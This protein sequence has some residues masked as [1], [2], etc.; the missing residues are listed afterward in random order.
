MLVALLVFYSYSTRKLIW[1]VSISMHFLPLQSLME[2]MK[3]KIETSP[4]WAINPFP[5]LKIPKFKFFQSYTY[6]NM[7]HFWRKKF[8]LFAVKQDWKCQKMSGIQIKIQNN[9]CAMLQS[10]ASWLS[11][12]TRIQ[13]CGG[14][15]C[16][17]VLA[18]IQI[19]ANNQP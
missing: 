7:L 17:R 14:R 10:E 19:L 3:L 13:R 1:L 12:P 8:I 16:I 15:L 9:F 18:K 5:L 6:K 11:A 4:H 2:Q